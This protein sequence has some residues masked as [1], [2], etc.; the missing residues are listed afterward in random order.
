MYI[1]INFIHYQICFAN[2]KNFSDV[3]KRVLVNTF[4]VTS[5]SAFGIGVSLVSTCLEAFFSHFY[6]GLEQDEFYFLIKCLIGFTFEIILALDFFFE[7]FYN[8]EIVGFIDGGLFRFSVPSCHFCQVAFLKELVYLIYLSNPLS[9][10]YM[11]IG[12][13]FI[14]LFI[15]DVSNLFFSFPWLVNLWVC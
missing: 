7:K 1:L 13:V 2:I 15:A 4:I 14:I 9:L 8:N 10:F 5:L 3:F 6:K 11:S 12:S